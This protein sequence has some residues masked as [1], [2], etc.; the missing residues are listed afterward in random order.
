[1]GRVLY[2]RVV[3]TRNFT[4]PRLSHHDQSA[5]DCADGGLSEDPHEKRR[6]SA[7]ASDKEPNLRLMIG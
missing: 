6:P 4:L 5:R 1:M 2:D 7:R 3:G